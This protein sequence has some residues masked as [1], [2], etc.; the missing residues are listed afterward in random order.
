MSPPAVLSMRQQETLTLI[1]GN[2][3]A[4]SAIDS[5]AS[6]RDAGKR[7]LFIG[8]FRRQEQARAVQDTLEMLTDQTIWILDQGPALIIK[9]KQDRCFVHGVGEFLD[10]CAESDGAHAAWVHESDCIVLSDDSS[11]TQQFSSALQT[12]LKHELKTGLQAVMA[13]TAPGNAG[14]RKFARSACF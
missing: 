5:A 11:A 1:G 10:A 12:R 13:V 6:W 8:H 7:I 2:S 3:A 4:N 9:R 14:C